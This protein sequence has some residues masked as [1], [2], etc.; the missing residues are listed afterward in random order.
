MNWK[1]WK[2]K[3]KDPNAKPKGFFREWADAITFA[4]VAATLIRWIFLEAFTIPTPSMENSLLMGDY[5]FVSKFHYGARTPKTPLQ[6]PLTHQYIWGT[7]IPSYLEWIQLPQY[8][9]PGISKVKNNDVVVFNWPADN[10]FPTD[11]KMNYIKRCLGIGG[12]TLQIINKQVYINGKPAANPPEMQYNYLVYS[13]DKFPRRVFRKYKIP[14]YG[15]E[16]GDFTKE[17]Q[18]LDAEKS[19][20]ILDLSTSKREAMLSDNIADSIRLLDYAVDAPPMSLF[21]F[22]KKSS[23]WNVDNYGPLWLPEEGVKVAVDSAFISTYET[24]IRNYEGWET[25]EVVKGKLIIEGNEVKEYTFQ[26]SYYFMMGDNR[27][28]SSDS[29]FWGF[30]PADHIVGKGF[31]IWLSI[32]KEG[33]WAD[34]IRWKRLF[35]IID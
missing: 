12:D 32:D 27:H 7:R 23:D 20:Y 28:N 34:K 14:N 5:L 11:L 4:V 1:F 6:I 29:R 26:Q 16:N 31:L 22:N 13:K 33:G 25:V 30:V 35:S 21:P 24:T 19:G 10:G 3:E 18:P 15:D 8:R 17:F 2:K 9:L